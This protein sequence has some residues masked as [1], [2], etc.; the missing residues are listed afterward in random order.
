MLCSHTAILRFPHS[1]VCEE[2]GMK[3]GA[4]TDPIHDQLIYLDSDLRQRLLKEYGVQGWAIAQAVGDA[5]FIPAGAP[6]Q[7]GVASQVSFPDMVPFQNLVCMDQ[8]QNLSS[9]YIL[10]PSLP[11]SLSP[12]LPPPS[13]PLSSPS[14]PPPLPL[15][16]PLF[17]LF[18]CRF[19]T[20]AAV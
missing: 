13:L 15:S 2:R 11:L 3:Q 1:Q 17:P 12:S 5:I 9:Y 4:G 10:S 18:W 14:L 6:H 7:V 19:E 8:Y 16:L 20:S